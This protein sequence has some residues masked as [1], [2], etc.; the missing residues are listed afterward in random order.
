MSIGLN[1]PVDL[2]VVADA[3]GALEAL[4]AAVAGASRPGPAW[5]AE[6]YA[7]IHEQSVAEA[8]RTSLAEPDRRGEPGTDGHGA[9]QLFPGTVTVAD[10]G[11][12][13]VVGRRSTRSTSR[14]RSCTR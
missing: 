13:D 6:R 1:R 5:R 3:R 10:G 4:L 7:A 11:N 8:T 9:A 2:A 12:T 14:T